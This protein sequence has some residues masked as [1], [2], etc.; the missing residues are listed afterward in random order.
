MSLYGSPYTTATSYRPQSTIQGSTKANLSTRLLSGS[1][2]Y[3]SA[4]GQVT[5][6]TT[7]PSWDR[8]FQATG[9]SVGRAAYARPGPATTYRTLSYGQWKK[10]EAVREEKYQIAKKLQK[11]RSRFGRGGLIGKQ[12]LGIKTLLRNPKR[13]LTADPLSKSIAKKVTGKDYKTL[14]TQFGRVSRDVLEDRADEVGLTGAAREKAINTAISDL[15][16]AG[17]YTAAMLSGGL[18]AG[19]AFGAASGA[20]GKGAALGAGTGA[21]KGGAEGGLGGAIQG[22]IGGALVGGATAGIGYGAGAAAGGSGTFAGQVASR[23]A[24][25]A[26][27]GY[28]S[29]GTAKGAGSGALTGALGGAFGFFTGGR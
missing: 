14:T 28:G 11:K 19:G 25:G 16:T 15:N 6:T 21:I 4:S 20:I 17:I 24:K 22:G 29:T 2:V 18:L 7:R 27:T 9:G 1:P 3:D 12:L 8:M 26:V 13:G 10:D 23:A 5:I